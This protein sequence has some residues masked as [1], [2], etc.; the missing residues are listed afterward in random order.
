MN[1]VLKIFIQFWAA[2]LAEFD[3]QLIVCAVHLVYCKKSVGLQQGV[4]R[5]LYTQKTSARN[6]CALILKINSR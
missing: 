5:F 4:R 1:G 2:K 6:R 3:T